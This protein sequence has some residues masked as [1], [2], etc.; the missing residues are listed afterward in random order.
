MLGFEPR[1]SPHRLSGIWLLSRSAGLRNG[2]K[3]GR[4]HFWTVAE[5]SL[6]RLK[7]DPIDPFYRHPVPIPGTTKVNRLKK[8]VGA[9]ALELTRDDLR[10]IGDAVAQIKVQGDRSPAHLAAPAGK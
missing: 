5:A 1:R 3:M 4:M 7:T 2:P 8:N 6:K 9:A 10:K